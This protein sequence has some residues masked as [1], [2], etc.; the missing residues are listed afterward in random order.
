LLIAVGG[1]LCSIPP[2]LANTVHL[3]RTIVAL[4]TGPVQ[5]VHQVGVDFDGL[6]GRVARRD[7]AFV[8]KVFDVAVFNRRAC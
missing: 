2:P 6:F 4:A 1:A 7:K 3:R 5:F 8:G